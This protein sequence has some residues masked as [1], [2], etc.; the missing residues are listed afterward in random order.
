MRCHYLCLGSMTEQV[1][2]KLGKV[3]SRLVVALI[4]LAGFGK[5][6]LGT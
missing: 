2:G 4:R 3:Q 5:A 1:S 6:I